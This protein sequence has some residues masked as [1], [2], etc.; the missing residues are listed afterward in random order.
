MKSTLSKLLTF[1][2]VIVMAYSQG[3]CKV[4]EQA[5]Q[6]EMQ[7]PPEGAVAKKDTA[8][9]KVVPPVKSEEKQPPAPGAIGTLYAVQIGAFESADNAARVE[10]LAKSRFAQPVRT[11]YDATMRLYKVSVGSFPI[12][13][14]ALEFRKTIQ[15]KY[16]GE[17]SDSWIVEVPK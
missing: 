12:R 5:E 14:S 9:V 2:F 16:P 10:Q 8:E 17:Y 13:D 6:E 4:S 7:T 15:Q 1:A 3:G 11:Y